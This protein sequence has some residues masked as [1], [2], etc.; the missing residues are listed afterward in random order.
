MMLKIERLA[1]AVLLLAAVGPLLAADAPQPPEPGAAVENFSL[2]DSRR[3]TRSLADYHDKQ[4]IVVVFCGTE[5]PMANLYVPT[6]IELHK[7]YRDRGVQ[8]LLINANPQD[9]FVEV[10]AHA[11]ER[12]I[13]FPVLK[14][15]DQAAAKALGAT[16]TPEAFVLSPDRVVLYHGRIDN[17]Y[18]I[19]FRKAEPTSRELK[20]ALEEILAGNSVSVPVTEFSGCVIGRTTVEKQ[21]ADVTFAKDVARILQHRCQECHRAGQIGPM[22][23]ATYEDAKAWSETI[24]EVVVQERM[25]PWHADARFGHFSNDRRLPAD[26]IETLLAWIDQG[27]VR[28]DDGDLPDPAKFPEGWVIGTPD[29]I[30]EMPDEFAVPASGVLDYQR[31]TIDPGFEEDVWVQAAECRPGN[32]AVV[33]HILVYIQM[34]GRPMYALDGTAH[35]LTGWAPGDMPATYASGTAKRIPAGA[36]LTFEVHYTPNGTEQTDRSSV[37]VVFAKE[38]PQREVKVNVLANMLLSIPPGEGNYH[39]EFTYKFR[40]DA[41]I[42]SF[43]PHMHLRG[44]SAKYEAEYPDGR[45]ETLLYVPDYDFNWQSIYRFKEPLKVPKGTKLKWSATWDNSADNPR[46]PDPKQKVGWG[47]QTWDEMQNGWMEYVPADSE[48]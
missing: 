19:G 14:D 48:D 42:L 4:A 47:L 29:R 21:R 24:R 10:A 31:F 45:R 22:P 18:R 46:N 8:F 25:P 1:F 43:M 44:T 37:G 7:E 33:H 15:F 3:R 6:L 12:E 9:S 30:F 13:P 32:R 11:M 36:K 5:C 2:S 27:C 20:S 41:E 34:P 40:K 35:T 26:E 39:D 16:R 38:P 17:Q 28:G 23:L